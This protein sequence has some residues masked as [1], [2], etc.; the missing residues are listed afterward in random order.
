MKIN[1][2]DQG[3][4]R[5]Q[6]GPIRPPGRP[7]VQGGFGD[8]L[9]EKLASAPGAAA[10]GIGLGLVAP[11]QLQSVAEAPANRAGRARGALSRPARRLSPAAG[12]PPRQPEGAGCGGPGDGSWQGR[13][14]TGPRLAAG[15]RRD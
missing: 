10:S 11:I 2:F 1:G 6:R 7:G 12:G 13:P 14:R 5:V 8:I 4:T 15:R 9:K 3:F